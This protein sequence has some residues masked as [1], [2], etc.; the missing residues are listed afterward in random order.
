MKAAL[1]SS[2][3]GGEG[4]RAEKVVRALARASGE[5]AVKRGWLTVYLGFAPGVGKTYAM[6]R[7]VADLQRAGN[8]VVVGY[9]ET[10][11]RAETAALL[12]GL[13]VLPRKVVE[14]KGVKVEELDVAAV[15]ARRPAICAI[16]EL[17]HTNA[18]GSDN[19]KRFED[20]WQVLDGGID[21][22]TTL[23]IQ[24]LESLNDVVESIAGVKVRE[25][26]PDLVLDEADEIVLVDISPE[27]L[28]D[29]LDQG[30][31]YPSESAARALEHF[32]RPG[33]LSA[34]RELALMRTA[35]SVERDL[36]SYMTAHGI[37][38]PWRSTERVLACVDETDIGETVVRRAFRLANAA[39]GELFVLTVGVDRLGPLEAKP[40]KRTLAV[41]RDLGATVVTRD[42]GGRD[43]AREIIQA[44][45]EL[46]ATLVLMGPSHRTLW[47]RLWGGDIVDEVVS[48][49]PDVDVLVIGLSGTD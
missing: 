24:H 16:D 10:H 17:A 23:N 47:E 13:E 27:E 29:R 39:R 35:R 1:N 30:K 8:D 42:G 41:A 15:L 25:R 34:L 33:N 14:Y 28:R 2:E 19:E 3:P 9:V 32:F 40:V 6:L 12:E 5:A 49:L 38:S 45:R 44:A 26:I 18:P 48:G 37:D 36:D 43:V 31:V 7:A 11:G 4:D 20:I 22:L 21:V 46:K